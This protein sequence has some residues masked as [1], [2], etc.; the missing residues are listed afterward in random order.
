LR[1]DLRQQLGPGLGWFIGLSAGLTHNQVTVWV[2]SQR[3][4]VTLA[5]LDD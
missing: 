4:T 5:G 2:D 3:H 1:F